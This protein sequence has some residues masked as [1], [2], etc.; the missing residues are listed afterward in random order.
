MRCA[1]AALVGEHDFRAFC[2]TLPET[3]STRR[4]ISALDIE[5]HGDFID[6]WVTADSFLHQMVRI[7]AGTLVE[8]GRGKRQAGDVRGVLVS[9]ARERA[10]FTAPAHALYLDYVHY[11]QTI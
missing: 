6:I 2:A 11:A 8:I 3:P 1:A 7:I 10:G 4:T 5:K 9:R